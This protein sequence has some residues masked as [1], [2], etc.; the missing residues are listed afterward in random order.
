MIKLFEENSIGATK[1]MSNTYYDLINAQL[2]IWAES[3]AE[4]IAPNFAAYHTTEPKINGVI[5]AQSKFAACLLDVDAA[6]AAYQ[7]AL[8]ARDAAKQALLDTISLVNRDIYDGGTSPAL[9]SATGLQPRAT[10]RTT[11]SPKRPAD[12]LAIPDAL[13]NVKL[14]W[15]R[16]QNP[17]NAV[18][19][20][21]TSADLE[22]WNFVSTTTKIK[23][24]LTGFP[25]GQTAYFRVCAQKNGETSHPTPPAA[26]YLPKPI[27]DAEKAA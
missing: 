24:T 21:E 6:R 23:I 15:K 2:S 4:V 5:E 1:N 22:N 11:H 8:E 10:R 26:I 13:G 3:Y 9:I 16:N 27:A 19:L 12:L 14:K 18:F 25:P 20:V 7:G 17:S